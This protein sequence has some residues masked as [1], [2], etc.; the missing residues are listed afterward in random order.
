MIALMMAAAT[1]FAPLSGDFDHDGR[2]DE[3]QIVAHRGQYVLRV[4]RGADP[5]HPVTIWDYGKDRPRSA[6]V[7]TTRAGRF[8][9]ACGKGYYGR[10]TGR[11]SRDWITLRKGDLSF[12]YQESSDAVAVWNGRRFDVEWMSD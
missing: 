4:T 6:F 7:D 8:Q 1:A 2:P 12:G 11:C 3:A 5:G 10:E 9:T